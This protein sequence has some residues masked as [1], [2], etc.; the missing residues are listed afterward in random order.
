MSTNFDTN[1][2]LEKLKHAEDNKKI[3]KSEFIKVD[4][5]GNIQSIRQ[6]EPLNDRIR[7][8]VDR[9][10]TNNESF[11]EEDDDISEEE[12]PVCK[13]YDNM[14]DLV[15]ELSSRSLSINNDRIKSVLLDLKQILNEN[16]NPFIPFFWSETFITDESKTVFSNGIFSIQVVLAATMDSEKSLL[17]YPFGKNLLLINVPDMDNLQFDYIDDTGKS[18]IIKGNGY[19]DKNKKLYVVEFNPSQIESL[20]LPITFHGNL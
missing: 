10:I 19:F 8:I 20:E 13:S 15:D 2:I 7:Q 5:D 18:G 6:S 16:D 14:G 1:S 4:C 11:S 17:L 9:Y 3:E 12:Q